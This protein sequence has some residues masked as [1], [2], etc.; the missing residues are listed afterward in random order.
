[1]TIIF[2]NFE[3][4]DTLTLTKLWEK[5]NNPI[6]VEVCRDTENYED[7]V[8]QAIINETETLIFCGHGTKYGLLHPNLFSGEYLLHENNVSLIHAKRVIGIWCH[9][10]D[11]AITHNLSGFYTGM[12]ISNVFESIENS[13]YGCSQKLITKR[14]SEFVK[15]LSD[16]II[17][18]TPMEEWLQCFSIT[19]SLTEFNYKNLKII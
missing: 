14:E 1:M 3:D 13:I 8:N 11:F 2:S 16:L 18:N 6:V 4:V 12:F 10:S 9:A 15:I 19:E 5:F 17:N 7:V